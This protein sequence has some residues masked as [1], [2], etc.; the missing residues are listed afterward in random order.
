MIKGIRRKTN[1]AGAIWTA[2]GAA[3]TTPPQYFHARKERLTRA[4]KAEM[5]SVKP[6]G[7]QH[8]QDGRKR[9]EKG[10]QR[11]GGSANRKKPAPN[12]KPNGK[13]KWMKRSD[14]PAAPQTDDTGNVRGRENAPERAIL[15]PMD[16]GQ[17]RQEQR[18]TARIRTLDAAAM[19]L[20]PGRNAEPIPSTTEDRRGGNR[21][22]KGRTKA[23]DPPPISSTFFAFYFWRECSPSTAP[24]VHH[25]PC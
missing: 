4:R 18:T 5:P 14:R 22:A 6:H 11:N 12:G 10:P 24:F 15:K 3:D 8:K 23:Q 9:N 25:P 7:K 13:P 2:R 16:K 21:K 20:T 1:A 17:E 19:A